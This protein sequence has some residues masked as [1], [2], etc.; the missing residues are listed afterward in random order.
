METKKIAVYTANIYR[1]MVKE[2]QYGLIQAAKREGVKLFFFTAFSDNFSTFTK[3]TKFTTYDIG[4]FAIYFLPDLNEFDGL[5]TM[6]TYLPDYYIDFVEEIKRSSPIPVV[7]LGNDVDF[8]YNVVNN[9]EKSLENLIDHLIEVHDCKEIVHVAGRL[10]LEFAQVRYDVFKKT[11]QKHNLPLNERNIVQ[12]N[13]WYDCG[14]P[15]VD[16]IIKDY[17][18][19]SDRILPDA[20]VCANDYSAIGVLTELAKRGINVPEDVIVTGYDNIPETMFTDPTITTSEQ[21]FEQVGKDGINTLV[22]LWKGKKIPRTKAVPGVLKCKQSCGCEPKH[23]YMRDL[24]KE[25]YS[26]TINRLDDLALSNTNLLLSALASEK[27]EDFLKSIETNCLVDTGFKNAVM[28]LMKG[29]DQHNIIRST[30]DFKDKEFEVVCG[31]YNGRPVKRGKLPKGQILPDDM[32]NDPEPYY[33]V[34]IHNFEY[35]MGYFIISPELE[36][37]SQANMKTWFLN[38]SI[39]LENWKTKQELNETLE[40]VRNL[41]NTDVLTKLYNRRGYAMF[42]DDYYKECYENKTGLCIFLID[43]DDMK[44]INDTLG[45]DEGDYCLCTI[46]KSMKKAAKDEEICIRAGGDEFI[47]L[48]KNYNEEKLQQYITNLRQFIDQKCKD[49]GKTY[50]IHVSIGSYMK[51][52][53]VDLETVPEAGEEYLRYADAEMYIE[54]KEHKKGK[55]SER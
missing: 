31:M 45:H 50:D 9:Q 24:L 34:P 3:Y 43:M 38:I 42:F 4:D 28:C 8:T 46:A 10:D 41:S 35:F 27:Y 44:T 5:I 30:D 40:Q 53:D 19:D 39:L 1:D 55:K 14:E 47:V 23:V 18:H 54:K 13:L 25:E 51:V 15:V 49:D 26:K 17:S 2:T 48:A 22:S 12:G 7:T 21:P 37:L 32:M 11:L 36:N 33:I 16:Q 20:I 6:D 29:W 52:P